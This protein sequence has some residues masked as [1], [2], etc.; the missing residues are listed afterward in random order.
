MGFRVVLA[1]VPPILR[2]IIRDAVVN[3]PDVEIVGTIEDPEP[4]GPPLERVQ[5][6]VLIVGAATPD[7]VTLARQVWATRPRLRL[8]TIGPGGRRAM[9]L[10]LRPNRVILG[11]ISPQG[12]VAAIRGE[13][14]W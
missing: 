7:D 4:L 6:D 3:A 11:D 10:E 13:P 2:D 1:H 9:L 8:L 14:A 5:A 12:L